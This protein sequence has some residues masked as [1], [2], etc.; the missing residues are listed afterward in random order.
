VRGFSLLE[1]AIAVALLVP[2]IAAFMDSLSKD[3]TA[4]RVVSS[5]VGPEMRARQ[6]LERI[7]H[8]LQYA[9]VRG[10][11][12]NGNG[13]VD[14][15]EATN[16]NL[17]FD[18]TWSLADG[19]TDQAHLTF[20]LREEEREGLNGESL[21]TTLAYSREIDYRVEDD[22]LVRLSRKVLYG[23][24]IAATHKTVLCESVEQIRFSRSGHVVTVAIDAFLPEGSYRESTRTISQRVL[25]R[26]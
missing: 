4:T 15:H 26:N 6:A 12:R 9:G 5:L 20:S 1:T 23:E 16:A 8:E 14:A 3:R 18:A 25:L 21:V 22:R 19:T 13:L 7:C 17:L 2:L 10:E 24:T 11:D